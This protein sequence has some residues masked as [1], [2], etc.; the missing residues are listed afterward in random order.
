MLTAYFDDSGTHGT[1]D[2]VLMGGVIGNQFQWQAVSEAWAK[3]LHDPSPG[4]LPLSLFHMTDCQSGEGEFFGWSR[5]ARE[6]LAHE[7]GSIILKNGIWGIA[8][9][10]SRKDY[11]DLVTGE[12]RRVAGDAETFCIIGCFVN[13]IK[14]AREFAWDPNIAFVFDDRPQKRRDISKIY[15][16]FRR[17]EATNLKPPEAASLTFSSSAKLLPLQ[18]ADLVAWEFYRDG[19][20]TL[21]GRDATTQ[22]PQLARLVAGGRMQS[23]FANRKTIMEIV[24]HE[25][26][27]AKIKIMADAMNL[28]QRD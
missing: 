13:A 19:L 21:A 12:L 22:R 6:F 27:P 7:L 20:N 16:V 4:K 1:S 23:Q 25:R 18:A 14:W 5:T 11:D 26:D 17:I 10:M 8:Q 28:D 2:V 9:G 3:K 15:D 24:N